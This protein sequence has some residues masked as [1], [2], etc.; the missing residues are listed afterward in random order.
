VEDRDAGLTGCGEDSCGRLDRAVDEWRTRER[1]GMVRVQVLQIDDEHGRPLAGLDP[2][3]SVAL[4]EV[5]IVVFELHRP[6]LYRG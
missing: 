2:A 1:R 4:E 6:R 3:L 5:R